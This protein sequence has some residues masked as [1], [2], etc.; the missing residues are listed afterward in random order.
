M[1][2]IPQ[3]NRMSVARSKEGAK[4]KFAFEPLICSICNY[5][6]R[7][8]HAVSCCQQ[9]FCKTCILTLKDSKKKCPGCHKKEFEFTLC[10]DLN[11]VLGQFEVH[12]SN[13][14]GWKGPLKDHDNHMNLNPPDDKRLEGCGKVKVK[15]I[16]C[17][18]ESHPRHILL[19]KVEAVFSAPK[20]ND[21]SKITISASEKW[22]Q[23]G[24]A[25]EMDSTTMEE[26]KSEY[27]AEGIHTCY[28]KLIK[29]W[30]ESSESANWSKLLTAFKAPSVKLETLF[31]DVERSKI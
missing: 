5:I 24:V 21:V 16:Y 4:C 19:T 20:W 17:G 12:C 27:E 28:C 30:I 25:L 15:C 7:E 31:R 10:E 26:I 23:I 13:K 22:N 29:K 8:P 2:E 1:S 3:V 6:L 9:T 11:K 18:E 14:C